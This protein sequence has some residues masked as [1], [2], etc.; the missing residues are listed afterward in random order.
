MLLFNARRSSQ[1]FTLI[2]MLVIVAIVGILSAIVA[3]SFLA[4]LNRAKVRDALTKAQGALQEAQREAIRKSKTCTIFVFAGNNASLRNSED[5]NG[6]GALNTGEDLNGNGVLDTGSC[7]VTGDRKLEG[8]SLRRPNT[9]SSITFTFKGGT[10]STGTM[11]FALPSSTSTKQ[12]CL[13]ISPGIGL[14]RSGNYA[15]NDTTETTGNNCT[16]SL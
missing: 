14:M 3:P 4:Y 6:N 5:L 2:E 9:I 13:S 8:I 10:S 16:T 15:D 7:L 1:G 11:V 12:K